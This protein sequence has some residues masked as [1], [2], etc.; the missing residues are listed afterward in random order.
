MPRATATAADLPREQAI[1]S[2]EPALRDLELLHAT[3]VTHAFA[4]HTHE[5]FAIGVIL[6]GA[7]RFDYRHGSHTAEA[8]LLV[9]INPG[10]VHTGSAAYRGGWRYRMLYP[11]ARL[12]QDAAYALVEG[13]RDIPF[14]PRPVIQDPA[15]AQS[16]VALHI[17][18]A[19]QASALERDSRFLWTLAQLI[20]R[21]AD[22]RPAVRVTPVE[23]GRMRMVE[24]YLDEH[25]A[26]Q[27]TLDD[28][29]RFASMSPFHLLRMFRDAVGLPP[30]AYL[31]Q[32]RVRHA[33]ALLTRGAS[34]ADVARWTGFAD[35]SHL[36]RHFK[37]I[38]GVPPGRY[39]Q[40]MRA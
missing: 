31:T 16:L 22:A 4:P 21:H 5:G 8:G 36:T 28:L 10:E 7:E 30:H 38:V 26:E 20:T 6:E 40:G 9:V 35:Q 18:L 34:I 11:D 3:Y 24:R 2:R 13:P 25:F 15:L 29:A 12:L 39:A 27:V 17:A 1:F 19:E 23:H 33:K 32:L 37:R 14:F